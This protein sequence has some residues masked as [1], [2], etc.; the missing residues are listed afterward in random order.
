MC[1]HI[2]TYKYIHTRTYIFHEGDKRKSILIRICSK[3]P[4]DVIVINPIVSLN[5]S[6]KPHFGPRT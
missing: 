4:G 1:I 3:R 5:S 6:K 2:N